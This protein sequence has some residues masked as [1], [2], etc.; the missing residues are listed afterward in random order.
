MQITINWLF[1]RY[2]W[3]KWKV[4]LLS[5][6]KEE[7]VWSIVASILSFIAI[8]YLVGDEEMNLEARI[9]IAGLIGLIGTQ[10]IRFL[11]IALT[12]PFSIIAEQEGIISSYEKATNVQLVIKRLNELWTSGTV[13][14]NS[15]EALMHPSR[16]EPWWLEFVEWKNTTRDTIALIDS[17]IADAWS[18]LGTY[19][20]KRNF[21]QA[22][23]PAH[24][25]RLQNF[26]AWLERLREII[27]RFQDEYSGKQKE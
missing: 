5:K 4:S 19:Q 17:N 11:W 10:I 9:A 12:A 26:D 2:A 13:L 3:N 7:G 8:G 18:T 27:N 22:F 16:V 24:H 15:G 23:D 21:P 20:P 25:K 6:W 14:R 1:F